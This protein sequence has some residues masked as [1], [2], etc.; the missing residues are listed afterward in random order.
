L[1]WAFIERGIE[2]IMVETE[3]DNTFE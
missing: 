2:V 3:K 1:R